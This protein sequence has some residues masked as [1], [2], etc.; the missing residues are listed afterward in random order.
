LST[1]SIAILPSAFSVSISYPAV[2][3]KKICGMQKRRRV[4]K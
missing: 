4:S 3:G 1:I 2:F